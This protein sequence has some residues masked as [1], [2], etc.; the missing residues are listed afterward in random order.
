MDPEGHVAFKRLKTLV[1]SCPKLYFIDNNLLVIFYTDAS[2]NTH[3]AYLCQLRTLPDDTRIKESIRFLGGTFQ[4][5]QLR[6]STIENE[7][8]AINWALL[9]LDDIVGGVHFII[10]TD[11]RNLLFRG[12]GKCCSGN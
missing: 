5:P 4:S 3:G 12:S 11:H 10:R 8:Y 7:A 6:W 2:N 1:N 9:R